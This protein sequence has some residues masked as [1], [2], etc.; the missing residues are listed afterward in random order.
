MRYK[1]LTA[2]VVV[3]LVAAIAL[4]AQNPLQR[5]GGGASPEHDAPGN[6]GAPGDAEAA[7]GAGRLTSRA[8]W[9]LALSVGLIPCPVSTVLLVYGIANGVLPLM[10]LMVI[11][12]SLGG[13]LTMSAISVA[14]ILGRAQLLLRLHGKAA[15]RL[16]A[17]LEFTAS[18]FIIVVGAILLIA[19]V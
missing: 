12:V 7:G 10:V 11:G 15:H 8:P 4:E 18:G 5:G 3:A 17:V 2:L 14:V 6:A 9:L 1:R 13:F 16:S 19:A